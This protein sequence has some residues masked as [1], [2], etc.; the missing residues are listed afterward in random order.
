M[1]FKFLPNLI[2]LFNLFLG[3]IVTLLL[4]ENNL[5]VK[6]VFIITIICLILDYL[7]GYIARKFNTKSDVGIQLDSLA[8]LVSFG[9]VPAILL[10]NMFKDDLAKCTSSFEW[11]H[12]REGKM[13]FIANVTDEEKF[14]A[15][16]EDQ[17][18]KDWNAKFNAKD[19]AWKL[20]KIM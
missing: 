3:C 16:F 7:D 12:I 1:N 8:D 10:Y 13:I 20:E 18:S 2:T 19:E 4:I 15:L 5:E 14:Y 11:A 9:L 17:R 6:N